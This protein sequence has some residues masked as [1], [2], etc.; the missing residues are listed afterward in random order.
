MFLLIE[1]SLSDFG[2][3]LAAAASKRS[4]EVVHLT[5]SGIVN[6]ISYSFQLG[7]RGEGLFLAIGNTTFT[8]EDIHGCFCGLDSFSPSLWSHFSGKDAEYAA[9]ETHALWLAILTALDGKSINPPAPDLLGGTVL[10][11]VELFSEAK[12]CGLSIPMVLYTESGVVAAELLEKGSPLMVADLGVSDRGEILFTSSNRSEFPGADNCHMVRELVPGRPFWI[13]L[14]GNSTLVCTRNSGGNPESCSA[15]RIPLK[16]RKALEDLQ[17]KLNL[18]VCE[19][20]F[21]RT[22][23]DRWILLNARRIPELSWLTEAEKTLDGI[24]NILPRQNI[25]GKERLNG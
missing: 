3:A 10:S 22:G 24:L 7:D 6:E 9:R 25:P 5:A 23:D 20:S 2:K 15:D 19:Y 17:R 12:E 16:T 1:N 21:V 14:T 8:I 11:P 18:R 13:S 4:M